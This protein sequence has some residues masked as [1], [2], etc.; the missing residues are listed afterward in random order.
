MVKKGV[1][2]RTAH[3]IIGALVLSCIERG[4]AIDDLTLEELRAFSGAF[5]A[6]VFEAISLAACVEGRRLPGGPAPE[7]VTRHIEYLEKI[8]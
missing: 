3:E 8:Y 4:V 6:D 1:P 7:A 2:F 5:D